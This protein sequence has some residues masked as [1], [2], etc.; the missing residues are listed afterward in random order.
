[1]SEHARLSASSA[2]RW[3]NCAG[4]PRMEAGLPD[5]DTEFSIEGTAAHELAAWVLR[6]PARANAPAAFLDTRRHVTVRLK[7]GGTVEVEV[8]DEMRAAV[9]LYVVLV[10]DAFASAGPE[11]KLY[12]EQK[13]SLAELAP[14]EPMFGTA[15]AVIVAPH[16]LHVIDFKYGVGVVVEVKDNPQLMEYAL[17]ARLSL[18]PGP[19]L[20]AEYRTTIVQ[21]RAPH[22]SGPVRSYSY[23]FVALRDFGHQLIAAAHAAQGPDAKLT[24]G[25]WCRWCKAAA[26][27][28]ALMRASAEAAQQDFAPVAGSSVALVP[29]VD[30]EY[31]VLPPDPDKL[32]I[33]Q[34]AAVLD[35]ADMVEGFLSAVRERVRAELEQGRVVPGWKLVAGRA[36]REWAYGEEELERVFGGELY[37]T[38]IRSPAALEKIIGKA[39]VPQ[40]LVRKESR[41]VKVVRAD[42]ARPAL[43]L[44]PQHEFA[45]LPPSTDST[46]TAVAADSETSNES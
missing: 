5:V 35:K 14:P 37:S 4:A 11:A 10:V 24:P 46:P 25:P 30:A 15:D 40:W 29:I 12:V 27:C 7:E 36:T 31:E 32:T 39:N 20:A 23:E 8:T 22:E 44:G 45:A 13:V 18:H 17:A 34:A 16:L 19:G 9:A 42:D 38:V 26:F 2:H 43:P 28:P 3:M 1:M 33:A 21:P 41:T 6:D